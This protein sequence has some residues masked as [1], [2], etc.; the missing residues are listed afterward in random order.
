MLRN[1]SRCIHISQHSITFYVTYLSNIINKSSIDGILC[2]FTER[3]L[4]DFF[5]KSPQEES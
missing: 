4:I 3:T 5:T 2:T 1:I